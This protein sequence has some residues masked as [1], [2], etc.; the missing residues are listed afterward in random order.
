MDAPV[1]NHYRMK[2]K[3][4]GGPQGHYIE[5]GVRDVDC[6]DVKWI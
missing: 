2:V 5:M 1:F 4:V 3:R 6:S